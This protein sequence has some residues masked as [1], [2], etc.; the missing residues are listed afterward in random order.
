MLATVDQRPHNR[1]ALELPFH[2]NLHSSFWSYKKLDPKEGFRLETGRSSRSCGWSVCCLQQYGLNFNLWEQTKANNNSWFW[3]H[4]DYHGQPLGL[5][6]HVTGTGGIVRLQFKEHCKGQVKEIKSCRT[7]RYATV[8]YRSQASYTHVTLT[9]W[10]H[11]ENERN[12]STK[13]HSNVYRGNVTWLH[14]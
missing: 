11:E 4:W 14:P 10:W 5:R 6:F 8:S 7:R 1:T 13:S 12:H 9:R 2:G 3:S